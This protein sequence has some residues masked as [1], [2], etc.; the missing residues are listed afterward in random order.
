M[1]EGREGLAERSYSRTNNNEQDKKPSSDKR[2][3]EE[4]ERS[5]IFFPIFLSLVRSI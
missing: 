4:E 2:G 3:K 5:F 1:G